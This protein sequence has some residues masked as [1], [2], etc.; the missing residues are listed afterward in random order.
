MFLASAYLG[1]VEAAT[2]PSL[3]T[4]LNF[5]V[6]GG[7]SVTN[8]GATVVNGNLGVSP[9]SA[10]TGFP[11]GVV[12]PPG[13][14]HAGDAVA[15]QA[16][17]DLTTAYNNLAGQPCN[18][19]LTGQ[20]LG[21]LTLTAGVYCFP[22]TSAQ[23]T[24][25]LTLDAQNNANSVFIFK[26][27]S[28]LT[29]ASSSSVKII[30]GG[31]AC[32]VFWQVGSSATLGSSTAFKGNIL[33]NTSITLNTSASIN[34][35][36]A[37]ARSGSVTMDTNTVTIAGCGAP[38]T[39]TLLPATQTAV[40]ATFTA[41]APS[42]TAV[43]ATQTAVAPTATKTGTPTKTP[44]TPDTVPP[45]GALTKTGTDGLG[46]KF[47]QI[48][49]RDIGSGLASI[50]VIKTI[51]AAT[52]VSSFTP[53]TTQPVIITSTKLNAAQGSTVELRITDIAGNVIIADP[54][55]TLLAVESGKQIKQTFR[56]IPAQEHFISVSNG[57]PGL[58]R[59]QIQ[60]NGAEFKLKNLKDDGVRSLD[61]SSAMTKSKNRITL[62]GFGPRGASAFVVI[63]DSVLEQ[64]GAMRGFRQVQAQRPHD[65]FTWGE[66]DNAQ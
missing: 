29:T 28:T 12:V 43:A 58:K 5:A 39:P 4:A 27:G 36:R 66:V 42:L 61:V 22:N 34:S 23:L 31:S 14:I 3:G 18:T 26:I 10:V 38:P 7:A 53:G 55:L 45:T 52:V 1:N 21:G 49:A 35:G 41:L 8:T 33:A 20:N 17:V 48:T 64:P 37:L 44:L 24:G 62:I 59:M 25:P 65:N 6:L 9:G 51:N 19:D 11:P 57:A 30:N 40:A 54:V 47:I 13:T 2:A 50:V 32:K 46:N 63:G 15:G 16:K 56:G 60:V